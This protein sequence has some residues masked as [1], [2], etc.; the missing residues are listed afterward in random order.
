[1]TS[2]MRI[3]VTAAALLAVALLGRTASAG[4]LPVAP[5]T[6][7]MTAETWRLGVTSEGAAA[8]TAINGRSASIA[9]AFRSNQGVTES[10]FIF[11]RAGR[12]VMV[13]SAAFHIL[14]R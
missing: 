4:R 3:I 10:Y 12:A 6:T 5:T 7:V 1:M 14:R 9:A 13:Q 2:L 8:Y 11:P